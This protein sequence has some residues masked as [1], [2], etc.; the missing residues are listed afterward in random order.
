MTLLAIQQR[1][2]TSEKKFSSR[3]GG[4]K[5]STYLCGVGVQQPPRSLTFLMIQ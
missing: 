2:R 1:L 3:F 5:N 4:L